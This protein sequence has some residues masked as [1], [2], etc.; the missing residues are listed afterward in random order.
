MKILLTFI[1]IAIEVSRVGA[2]KIFPEINNGNL[3]RGIQFEELF[4]MY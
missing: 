1:W 2:P 3:L 4:K